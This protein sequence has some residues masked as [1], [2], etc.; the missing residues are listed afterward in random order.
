MQNQRSILSDILSGFIIFLIALPLSVG[1][2]LASGAPPTAGILAAIIGGVVGAYLG[3]SHLAI[4]GPAAGLIVIALGAVQDLGAGDPQTGFRRML[5]VVLVAGAAQVAMGL[6]RWGALGTTVPGSVIHGMLSAIGAIIMVKQLPVAMGVAMQ[7]KDIPGMLAEL[8]HAALGLNPEVALIAMTGFAIIL[9]LNLIQGKWVRY[10]PAPLLVVIAGFGFAK[11][12]DF[13]HVHLVTSH[14]LQFEVGPKLLLNLPH[15]LAQAIIFPDFSVI[16]S[17]TSLRYVAMVAIVGSIESLLTANAVDRLDPYKRTSNLDRELWSKGV[18]NMVCGALGGL[19][20][21]AEIVRSS[22]NIK[23]GARTPLANF[24]HGIF[25]LVFL[26]LLPDLLR[27]IPLAA[28]AAILISVG[29]A[30]AHPRQFLKT[31]S[32]GQDHFL[33]FLTTFVLTLAT[34]LLVGVA[35]GILVELTFNFTRGT[36][37]SNL[38]RVKVDQS[39]TAQGTVLKLRTPVTFTNFLSLRK[40]LD[41]TKNDARVILDL[42]DAPVVDHTVLEQLYRFQAERKEQGRTLEISFSAEHRPTS[43]HPLAAL[44]RV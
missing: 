27:E 3:G 23:N 31:F 38:F 10:V 11:L 1:I 41:S 6:A 15:N 5:A 30:L 22:A 37:L 2:A 29:W 7:S 33:A 18:C 13:D 42:S 12:F 34:D 43:K 8:P 20:I 17:A 40:I 24:C 32:V 39:K 36:R 4:N 21:I 35:A 19:P 28:L 14:W 9:S 25:I 16:L 44:R 26:L